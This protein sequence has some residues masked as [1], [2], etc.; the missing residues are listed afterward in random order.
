M[1][2][3]SCGVIV[4]V[5]MTD[6]S[7]QTKKTW[8]GVCLGVFLLVT[9]PVYTYYVLN[10]K[11]FNLRPRAGK[12]SLLTGLYSI[13]ASVSVFAHGFSNYDANNTYSCDLLHTMGFLFPSCFISPLIFRAL[14]VVAV[15]D[16]I[17]SMKLFV[18]T[19]FSVL[20]IV[21]SSLVYALVGF[22]V[23]MASGT[24]E[25]MDGQECVAFDFWIY[26]TVFYSLILLIALPLLLKMR[27]IHD[28]FYIARE[29]KIQ[30]SLLMIFIL[31]YVIVVIVVKGDILTRENAARDLHLNYL[32]VLLCSASFYVSFI[33]P[34]RSGFRRFDEAF[35]PVASRNNSKVNGGT[36]NP[37]QR[38]LL[39]WD[40]LMSKSL[41]EVIQS[42]DL[43]Y[44]LRRVAQRALCSE[45]LHFVLAV[46]LYK[47]FS[48]GMHQTSDRNEINSL[49]IDPTHNDRPTS[50]VSVIG[51]LFSGVNVKKHSIEQRK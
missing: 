18:S 51:T 26:F 23:V 13:L 8:N 17:E 4:I 43:Y 27:H 25:M 1:S 45:L 35:T 22:L 50:V 12:L 36:Q 11:S 5:E 47:L 14:K 3:G 9:I 15:W 37:L 30:F 31:T 32:L 46:R 42:D 10:R 33:D 2:I 24:D 16:N 28:K 49:S 38:S 7:L 41:E 44:I 29:M 20:M 40:G 6:S 19:R 39:S 21:L 48:S 34:F